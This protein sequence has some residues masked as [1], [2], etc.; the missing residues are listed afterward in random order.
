[1]SSQI[2]FEVRCTYC[3][4]PLATINPRKDK[5]VFYIEPCSCQNIRV[6]EKNV[7]PDGNPVKIAPF[8]C[9]R[10]MGP[11]ETTPVDMSVILNEVANPGHTTVLNTP[12]ATTAVH[13]CPTCLKA[14]QDVRR[15]YGLLYYD[16]FYAEGYHN[17]YTEA[18]K[19]YL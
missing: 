3:L 12:Q 10:C 8:V 4:K 15:E 13:L 5:D 11:L 2:P 17:G 19:R 18:V 6:V 1:M 16:T 7:K 14:E 9:Y